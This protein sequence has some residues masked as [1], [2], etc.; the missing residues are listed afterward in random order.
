MIKQHAFLSLSLIFAASSWGQSITGQRIN[1]V[2]GEAAGH[3]CLELDL[4]SKL[5]MNDYGAVLANDVWGWTDPSTDKEYALAGHSRGVSF[6]D[7]TDPLNP[8]YLGYLPSHRHEASVWRDFKVYKNHVFVVVDGTGAN[9]MQVFDLTELRTTTTPKLFSETAHYDKVSRVHNIAINERTGFA[10]LVGASSS[11]ECPRGLHIVDIT[12]P[13]SPT[14]AGCFRDLSTGRSRDGYV[15]D[16]QC[17][18]YHGPD[19]AYKGKEICVSANET[20]ISIV[21]VTDKSN[22]VGLSRSDYPDVGYAHQGWLS[23]DH[24][25]FYLNDEWDEAPSSSTLSGTRTIIW[26]V[27]DLDDPVVHSN[28]IA[29][30][31]TVDH[32]LYVVG[33]YVL[34]ANYTSGLRIVSFHDPSSPEEKAFFDTHPSSNNLSYRGAWSVYPYFKSGTIVV[35]SDPDGLFMLSSPSH[36]PSATETPEVPEGFVLSAAYPNPFNPVTTLILSMPESGLVDIRVHDIA[37]REVGKLLRGT[38]PA[39]SHV[40]RFEGHNLSSG[41]YLI[42]AKTAHGVQTQSVTLLK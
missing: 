1:C 29:P 20:H 10:Y 26:D 28:Y 16:V 40:L 15:H 21:D 31:L 41:T 35:S 25:Y 36:I 2:N 37:G 24:R 4:L 39:G 3:A 42:V 34:M 18:I 13:V 5:S 12:D 8:I 27:E 30:V 14:Y 17:V 22:I 38:L 19:V 7:I 6:V 9:G 11:A 33:K 23:E 32:N